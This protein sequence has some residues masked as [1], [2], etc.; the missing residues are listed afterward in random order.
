MI[1]RSK[2]LIALPVL[3]LLSA[4][5]CH[6]SPVAE[7]IDLIDSDPGAVRAQAYDPVLNGV[8]LG[9]GS[10]RIHRPDVGPTVILLA[11]LWF[12]GVLAYEMHRR[13]DVASALHRAGRGAEAARWPEVVRRLAPLLAVLGVALVIETGQQN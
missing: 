13:C 9:S 8:E 7:D 4:G 12:V 5:A 6:Y 2:L 11:P 1:S 10:I 3:A